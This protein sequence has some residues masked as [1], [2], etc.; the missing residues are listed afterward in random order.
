LHRKAWFISYGLLGL[1]Q[2]ALVPV[3]MPLIAPNSA[4][5][6]LTYAMFSFLG[7]F[8][9]VLGAWADRTGRHRDL[10]IW[11][12]LG[13]GCLLLPFGAAHGPLRL[14]LAAGAG[15]GVMATTTAGNVL[16]IQGVPEDAWDTRVALLQRYV[17]A[18]QVIGLVA[19]GWL[20]QRSA[21]L[22]FMVA[23]AALLLAG[24]LAIATAPACSPRAATDKPPPRP[25][26]GGDAGIAGPHHRGHHLSLQELRSFLGVI[27]Q[28]LRRFLIVWLIAYPA[29]NGFATLFPVA[30]TREFGMEAIL[31]S[32]AYAV[33]VAASLLLYA[34][35]G[36]VTH[37][38][39]GGRMLALGMGGR[40]L[41]L[42]LLVI[43]GFLHLGWIG[44][45]VLIGFALIQF[46]WPLLAVAANS[47]AVRFAPT[48]RGESVGLFNAATSLAAAVGSALA[49]V[50]FDAA[51]F[52]GLAAI[53][54]I[55]VGLAM[56][57]TEVWLVKYSRPVGGASA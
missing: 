41:V 10:L 39:G 13:A 19:A 24:L 25:M 21:S 11:G 52:A 46:V 50:I 56:V 57:L 18:G 47:L 38:V 42:I 4:A 22:G 28:P 55:M 6:G 30:M 37:R 27:T 5:A 7:L 33:G 23:G 29:M 16:A 40:L 14:L 36:V 43:A 51:G 45:L 2:N 48:A 3:L 53:T 35:I 44:W 49:G 17:S 8:A 26:M 1:T 31:P 20:A 15:L 9:P 32:S 34:P 54:C 12:T